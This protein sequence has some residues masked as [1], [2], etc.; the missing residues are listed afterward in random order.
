MNG[1][2]KEIIY[3]IDG[4]FSTTAFDGT[5]RKSAAIVN[6][7]KHLASDPACKPTSNSLIWDNTIA[8]DETVKVARVTI[9]GLNPTSI[10]T[11][12]GLKA[13]PIATVNDTIPE[14]S[15]TFTETYSVFTSTNKM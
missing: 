7:Y 13:E 5:Q 11:G 15:T 6:N 4:T 8:C 9:S 1:H 3:D 12:V 2:K 14:T 10:F